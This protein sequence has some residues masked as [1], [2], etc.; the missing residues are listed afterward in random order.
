MRRLFDL[1]TGIV[2]IAILILLALLFW[3]ALYPF[4]P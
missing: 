4:T 2:V 3:N 1:L